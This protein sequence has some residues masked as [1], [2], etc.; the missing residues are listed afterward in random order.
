M[1]L[2]QRAKAIQNKE[3]ED[4]KMKIKEAKSKIETVN[5]KIMESKE[6]Q[7]ILT[8]NVKNLIKY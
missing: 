7:K 5:K 4:L 2:A 6:N 3:L 8:E 1:D